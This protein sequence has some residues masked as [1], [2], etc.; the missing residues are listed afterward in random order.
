M[1]QTPTEKLKEKRK[2]ESSL[3]G[4][5][6][7]NVNI[8]V[9]CVVIRHRGILSGR[10]MERDRSLTWNIAEVVISRYFGFFENLLEC[11]TG[12]DPTISFI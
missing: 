5:L 8:W 7:R 10:G 1:L 11:W 12:G 4:A 9:C 3:S 2:R 6:S